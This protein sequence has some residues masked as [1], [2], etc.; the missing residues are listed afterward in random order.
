MAEG[1]S[2]SVVRNLFKILT[3]AP[4]RKIKPNGVGRIENVVVAEFGEEEFHGL[5]GAV[6]GGELEELADVGAGEV[7]GPVVGFGLGRHEPV[8]AEGVALGDALEH[9]GGFEDSW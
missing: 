5:L 6:V 3:T 1:I 9:D 8:E 4:G 2:K 7:G